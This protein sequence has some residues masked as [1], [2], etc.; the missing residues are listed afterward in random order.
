[1]QGGEL[2][3]K[4]AALSNDQLPVRL[5]SLHHSKEGW[6]KAGV[7]FLF[8]NQRSV[9]PDFLIP[10]QRPDRFFQFILPFEILL[11]LILYGLHP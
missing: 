8:S 7:V 3:R 4:V 1:M 6:P 10:V 11:K 5:P 9:W 2:A